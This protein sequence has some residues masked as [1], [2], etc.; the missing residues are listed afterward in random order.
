MK[1]PI[2]AIQRCQFLHLHA[3]S[4]PEEGGV[5]LVVHEAKAGG[6]VNEEVLDSEPLAEVKRILAQSS[7]IVHAGDC[8]VFTITWLK[9]IGYCVENESFALPEPSPSVGEGRLLRTYS[10]SVYLDF[11]AK[12]S[13]ASAEYPGPFKHWAVLCLDHIV[14]VVST[15]EPTIHA[16]NDA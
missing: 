4:E 5:R 3:I 6:P 14:N 16:T 11:I 13:F 15:E 1:D 7:T 2:S 10:K 9:Y 8:K 12:A